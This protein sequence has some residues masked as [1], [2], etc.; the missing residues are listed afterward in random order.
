MLR[1]DKNFSKRQGH[2]RLAAIRVDDI[3]DSL[4]VLLPFLLFL[5]VVWEL[6]SLRW[7][8]HH[9]H[10]WTLFLRS[11]HLHVLIFFSNATE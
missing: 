3:D 1:K 2:T 10:A 9:S 6:H 5:I 4:E 8:S 11:L 7:D